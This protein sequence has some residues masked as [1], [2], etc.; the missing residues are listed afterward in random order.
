MN[1]VAVG[2]SDV[3]TVQHVTMLGLVILLNQYSPTDL[4]R[5]HSCRLQAGTCTLDQP[6]WNHL[7]AIYTILNPYL[8]LYALSGARKTLV[9]VVFKH[10]LDPNSQR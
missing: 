2:Q 6:M 5:V 8:S 4:T 1:H 9:H 3:A 10:N 7:C